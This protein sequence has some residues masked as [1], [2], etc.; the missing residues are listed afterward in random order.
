MRSVRFPCALSVSIST[1]CLPC[2]VV[3]AFIHFTQ[4]KDMPVSDVRTTHSTE[5]DRRKV[6]NKARLLR[7]DHGC[8]ALGAT[9]DADARRR[10]GIRLRGAATVS[11]AG[12]SAGKECARDDF[13]VCESAR[14]R[15]R[16][17]NDTSLL[18]SSG[19]APNDVLSR[20]VSS[21]HVSAG[22][23]GVTT[24]N[25]EVGEGEVGGLTG[26]V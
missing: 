26:V 20:S 1:A 16:A 3:I 6:D 9:L 13:S 4:V 15:V 24:G 21:S 7:R 14:I 23:E 25:G 18:S 8:D 5:S 22:I 12:A 11:G 17:G 10:V 2:S 19:L